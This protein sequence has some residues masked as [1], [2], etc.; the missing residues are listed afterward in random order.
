MGEMKWIPVLGVS[1][2]ELFP[3]FLV[4]FVA[5]NLFDVWG[6]LLRLVGFDS[7]TFANKYDAV[8]SHEGQTYVRSQRPKIEQENSEDLRDT[9]WIL[10]PQNRHSDNFIELNSRSD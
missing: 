2:Q 9:R 8:K 1:F 5:F 7:I 6:K 3:I 10:P 4:V